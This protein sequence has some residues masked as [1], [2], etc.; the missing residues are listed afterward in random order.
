M[1]GQR[2]GQSHVVSEADPGAKLSWGRRCQ[3]S[4]SPGHCALAS[5]LTK[6]V[7]ACC[8]LNLLMTSNP[9]RR[10]PAE[11]FQPVWAGTSLKRRRAVR[12]PCRRQSGRPK[13]GLLLMMR[14]RSTAG[15]RLQAQQDWA[16]ST[17]SEVTPT[18]LSTSITAWRM[19]RV[20][21]ILMIVSALS[22]ASARL[23]R[24]GRFL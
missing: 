23:P 21:V 5:L 15:K 6:N 22:L 24:R 14:P 7:Q 2:C 1:S 11:V 8:C 12:T 20:L 18:A 16:T 13:R 19:R 17:T 10:R 4:S 3:E 9:A